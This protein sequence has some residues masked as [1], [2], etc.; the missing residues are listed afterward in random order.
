MSKNNDNDDDD[1]EIEDNDILSTDGSNSNSS[2]FTA[3][4]KAKMNGHVSNKKSEIIEDD[5]VN[6]E[7]VSNDYSDVVVSKDKYD[8][9]KSEKMRK[10]QLSSENGVNTAQSKSTFTPKSPC[11]PSTSAAVDTKSSQNNLCSSVPSTSS[12]NVQPKQLRYETPDSEKK[13]KLSHIF[14]ME[15]S[16]KW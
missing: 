7:E 16:K 14:L 5:D 11:K 4:N 12:V 6:V 13:G 1:V 8:R 2:D 15:K 9:E 3:K 10:A